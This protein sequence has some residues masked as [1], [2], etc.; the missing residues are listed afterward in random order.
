MHDLQALA[1]QPL[2]HLQQ[3]CNKFRPPLRVAGHV[4]RPAQ[5]Q[6]VHLLC[7]SAG[8]FCLFI[9]SM[10]VLSVVVNV[11]EKEDNEQAL[12]ERWYTFIIIVYAGIAR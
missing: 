5:L 4:H 11:M 1:G 3:L 9:V 7:E 2:Q 6:D 12:G 8:Q 10:G